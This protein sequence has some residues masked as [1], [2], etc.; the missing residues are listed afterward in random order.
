MLGGTAR[1]ATIKR[2]PAFY[3]DEGTATDDPLVESL[4]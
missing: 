4:I 2:H 1:Q 3:D